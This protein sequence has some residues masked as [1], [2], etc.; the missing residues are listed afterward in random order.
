MQGHSTEVCPSTKFPTSGV[1]PSLTIYAQHIGNS[2]KGTFGY[3]Q[4]SIR[5][6]RLNINKVNI[7]IKYLQRKDKCRFAESKLNGL[8]ISWYALTHIR[9]LLMKINKY[10]KKR[11]MRFDVH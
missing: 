3:L 6:H 2:L 9:N 11:F 4:I 1:V 5:R 7:S 8:C 10:K